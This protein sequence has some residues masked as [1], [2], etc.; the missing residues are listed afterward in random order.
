MK[1]DLHSLWLS[2][3]GLAFLLPLG[4]V[5][6]AQEPPVPLPVQGGQ[7]PPP[8][9]PPEIQQ[10]QD[11]QEGSIPGQGPEGDE[12]QG[13][14]RS[15]QGDRNELM[16]LDV[17]VEVRAMQSPPRLAPGETGQLVVLVSVFKGS[18]VLPGGH[19][20]LK[21]SQGPLSLGSPVWDPIP[22]GEG[23]YRDS[24][25]VRVPLSVSSTAKYGKY[26][27]RGSIVMK[28]VFRRQ[29]LRTRLVREKGRGTAGKTSLNRGFQA[30][31]VVGKPWPKPPKRHR[32]ITK[33][34]VSSPISSPQQSGAGP[35]KGPKQVSDLAKKG[36]DDSQLKSPLGM[37]VPEEG[38]LKDPGE[39]V[40]P[41]ERPSEG[42][43]NFLKLFSGLVL[44][45]LG[46][47]ALFLLLRK[48]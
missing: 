46:I 6:S 34:R 36:G 8:P 23:G 48:R 42:G 41:E 27:L 3:L 32:K 19:V 33:K 40:A 31:I 4:T 25:I 1:K 12:I 47:A 38:G 24:F 9:P 28:G 5:L 13:A 37:T 45:G 35:S 21:K 2:S 16:D 14:E 18:M 26:T 10:G 11:A 15:N 44:V 17:G 22:S 30:V 43:T 7:E 20:T 29:D 39:L